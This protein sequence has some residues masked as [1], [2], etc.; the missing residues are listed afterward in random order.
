M[1]AA[2]WKWAADI[3]WFLHLDK[4]FSRAHARYLEAAWRMH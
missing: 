4:G 2:F 1:R 3:L